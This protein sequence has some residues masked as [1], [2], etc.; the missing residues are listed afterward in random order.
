[1]RGLGRVEA[2]KNRCVGIVVSLLVGVL[3]REGQA[4][5]RPHALTVG[6]SQ[7][8]VLGAWGAPLEREDRETKREATWHYPGRAMVAFTQGKVA[9]WDGGTQLR[10]AIPL[11]AAMAAEL[12]SKDTAASPTVSDGEMQDI[13]D[14]IVERSAAEPTVA[15]GARR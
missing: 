8:E 13:L 5:F 1:M 10:S 11:S 14:E 15:P 9:R 12:D 6:M 7:E 2:M 4:D 3:A